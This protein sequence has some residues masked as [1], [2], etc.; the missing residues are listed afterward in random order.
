[1]KRPNRPAKKLGFD[2]DPEEGAAPP[3]LGLAP[4]GFGGSGGGCPTTVVRA[5]TTG[6]GPSVVTRAV[7]SELV[8]RVAKLCVR[9]HPLL[10]AEDTLGHALRMAHARYVKELEEDP[11][12][13]LLAKL[14]SAVGDL[15][16]LL[17]L[18]PGQEAAGGGGG[19]GGGEGKSAPTSGPSLETLL[20]RAYPAAIPGGPAA[21]GAP[22]DGGGGGGGGS[23]GVPG[24]GASTYPRAASREER[25]GSAW[26]EAVS[27]L[28][29]LVDCERE[30]RR[31]T[32]EV[33]RLW[34]ELEQ[35]RDETGRAA[36]A[37]WENVAG[38]CL[39][40]GPS[41]GGPR[42]GSGGYRGAGG[43][44]RLTA[45]QL[46]LLRRDPPDSSDAQPQLDRAQAGAQGG[47]GCGG[48]LGLVKRLLALHAG[49]A[50]AQLA[51]LSEEEDRRRQS[52]FAST[53]GS[54]GK[55]Q[56]ESGEVDLLGGD[57]PA[58]GLGGSAG[59]GGGLSAFFAA[60]S[61][62]RDRTEAAK[63]LVTSAM[64]FL[65]GLARPEAGAA[66]EQLAS[67]G[68]GKKLGKGGK[69]EGGGG[70]GGSGC[71][72]GGDVVVGARRFGYAFKLG[73]DAEKTPAVELPP[74]LKAKRMKLKAL[75]FYAVL[76][77]HHHAPNSGQ[78][79]TRQPPSHRDPECGRF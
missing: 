72:S 64:K 16:R 17:A 28:S 4:G 33:Y 29:R 70:G 56:P 52:H 5:P 3:P 2:R 57:D 74:S 10:M 61:A 66:W 23:A 48:A 75:R 6:V 53:G 43:P 49:L 31:V 32:K 78:D 1:M 19:L 58:G 47:A 18:K 41:F 26:G 45:L 22:P 11:V 79:V 77:V 27:C 46:K 30:A 14:A 44:V 69:D 15:E 73:L 50:K 68:G 24:V 67:G 37:E 13:H 39:A 20:E 7:A 59:G 12:A 40:G 71:G 42:G 8:V 65:E 60:R 38:S 36:N 9:D 35:A 62:A 54:G 34:R 63:R 21:G 25:L 76:S 55:E 51:A